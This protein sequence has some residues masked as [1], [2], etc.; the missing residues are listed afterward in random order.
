MRFSILFVVILLNAIGFSQE[1][2]A[3]KANINYG[4]RFGLSISD[5]ATTSNSISP[6]TTFLAG[7]HFQYHIN[8]EW[9]IQP[10]LLYVRKGESKRSGTA[11]L[12]NRVEN[13]VN[14]DYVEV[15]LLVK[16]RLT[17]GLSFEAGPYVASLL[18]AEQEGISTTSAAYT[19]IDET[20]ENFDAGLALG[21]VFETDWNFF[22]GLRYTRGFI[23]I[24][25]NQNTNEEGYHS[26]IQMYFGYSF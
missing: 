26:Q 15:P 11:A 23:S 6:R 13:K 21:A 1:E 9:S 10:E 17:S 16:Y 25:Q 19:S 24:Y 12:G 4:F 2:N 14:L 20:I 8:K 5:V 18:K 22:I 7:F 3:T